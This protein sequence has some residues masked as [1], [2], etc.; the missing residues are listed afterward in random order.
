LT[1]DF[2]IET[3]FRRKIKRIWVKGGYRGDGAEIKMGGLIKETDCLFPKEA[4]VQPI[5]KGI[6]SS[7]KDLTAGG[8]AGEDHLQ[9]NSKMI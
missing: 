8:D 7:S 9:K 5:R 4:T 2:R 1:L 3:Q 6:L